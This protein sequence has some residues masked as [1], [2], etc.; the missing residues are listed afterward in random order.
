VRRVKERR[1]W[2]EKCGNNE[3]KMYSCADMFF[4]IIS[5]HKVLV[6][7][8]LVSGSG[9]RNNHFV[10]GAAPRVAKVEESWR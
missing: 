7:L 8:S 5:H 10:S 4:F 9:N 2:H 3:G 1:R 6:G